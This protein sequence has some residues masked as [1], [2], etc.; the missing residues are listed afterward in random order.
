VEI[1]SEE[2]TDLP[3]FWSSE[4]LI[5]GVTPLGLPERPRPPGETGFIGWVSGSRQSADEGMSITLDLGH[6]QR[7][8]VE[9]SSGDAPDAQ[10]PKAR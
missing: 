5:D 9:V 10:H 4:L 3:S 7:F 1:A 2:G 8:V 6:P